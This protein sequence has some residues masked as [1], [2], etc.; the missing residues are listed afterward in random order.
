MTNIEKRLL[1][2][3]RDL[4]CIAVAFEVLLHSSTSSLRCNVG[5]RYVLYLPNVSYNVQN[6]VPCAWNWEILVQEFTHATLL[7]CKH[8]W[9]MRLTFDV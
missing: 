6:D 4:G 3:S 2:R 5:K 1:P 9:R 8:V 7:L